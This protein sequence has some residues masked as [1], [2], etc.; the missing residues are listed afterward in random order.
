VGIIHDDTSYILNFG[1]THIDTFDL[2]E[3]GG[4]TKVFTATLA[5]KLAEE[6]LIDL[7]STI[8]S[9]LPI[10]KQNASLDS[11]T[12]LD[13]MMHNIKFPKR[14]SNLSTREYD[15]SSPYKYY[16]KEDLLDF[17]NT[18]KESNVTGLWVKSVD[19]SHINYALLEIILEQRMKMP[20]ED[21]YQLYLFQ[22]LGLFNTSLHFPKDAL[23]MGFDR[24]NMIPEPWEFASFSGSEGLV[25][26]MYDLLTFID[27]SMNESKTFLNSTLQLRENSKISR[28]LYH[29][30][31]WYVMKSRK[32][33]EIH[34]HSGVTERHKAYMH[35]KKETK[36][37]VVI[38][39]QSSHGVENLG[40]LILRMI[41]N[42][43]NK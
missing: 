32:A 4:L 11:Y 29:T 43:W 23:I 36:T 14:P 39:C 7:S 6:E 31:A 41:N 37:G 15:I 33:G 30:S 12:L 13:L 8:N 16:S 22:D 20:L 9:N 21:L 3:I 42:N 28:N 1:P 18:Y 24:S 10:S 27:L 17:Y 26:C 40:L 19:Y 35:F 5:T 38:L 25:S 2:F 34:T